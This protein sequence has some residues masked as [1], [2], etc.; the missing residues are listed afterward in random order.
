[1]RVHL[2]DGTYE[3]FRFHFSPAGKHVNSSG[4]LVGAVRGVI[5]SIAAM[6]LS[7]AESGGADQGVTHIGVATDHVV[8]S[9]RNDLWDTYKTGDDIDPVLLAQFPLLE[10]AIAALGVTCWPMVEYEADDALGAAAQLANEDP[11]VTSVVICSPDKDLAQCVGGKVVQ[12]DRRAGEVRDS[13]AVLEKYG[14]PPESI[15]DFLGLVG[16][17][18]DG[19]PGVPGWGAKSTGAILR[20]YR[21]I[22]NIPKAP[23]QWD[24]PGLRGVPKLAQNL[25]DNYDNA[26]LFKKLATLVTDI[27][28]GT[29]D[30]WRWTGPTEEFPEWA[31]RLDTP[32]LLTK[33]AAR[34]ER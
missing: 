14:V 16:D 20:Q 21:H 12:F 2:L 7:D 6:L 15:P 5:R 3:L 18:A 11:R 34:S 8:R 25:L 10:Q 19:F 13:Q 27:D 31:A 30:A 29:V 33:L 4:E 24:V 32:E 28:V 22:E 17:S 9:F 23:G 26:L 1:M